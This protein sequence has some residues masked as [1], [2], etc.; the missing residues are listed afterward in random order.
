MTPAD[1]DEGRRDEETASEYVRRLAVEKA[2]RVTAIAPD[3]IVLG[4]DTV[5]L[6]EGQ[7][8]GKPVNDADAAAM[9]TRLSGRSHEVLTGV[10]VVSPAWRGAEVVT[11]QVTFR[12]LTPADVAWYVASQE[13]IGKAGA[14]AIQGRASRF[15]TRIDGSYSN[16][17]GLPM[18]TVDAMLRASGAATRTRPGP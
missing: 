3:A 2:A 17:V 9:L 7:L 16:V 14:Y 10:A 4:G 18:A 13:P 5:V 12:T 1:I 8:L 11:T 6:V 15:V